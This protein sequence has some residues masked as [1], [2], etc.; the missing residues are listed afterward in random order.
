MLDALPFPRRRFLGLCLG[1]LLAAGILTALTQP[2]SLMRSLP[3]GTMLLD[4]NGQLLRFTT[5]S[6][7]RY[8]L[9]MNLDEYAPVLTDA[10]LTKEDRSFW[11][12]PGVDLPALANAALHSLIL[13]DYHAGAST[14]TMQLVRLLWKLDTD[15]I[16][17]KLL[18]IIDAVGLSV[19]YSK[20]EV[21]E[22]YFNL[23]PCGGNVEG[24]GTASR[25]FFGKAPNR[26]NL[27]EAM[28]LAVLPQDPAHRNP[29]DPRSLPAILNARSQL[30]PQMVQRF[31]GLA[32]RELEL[33]LPL[34]FRHE[35]PFRA[36][37]FSQS[38]IAQW[39]VARRIGTSL[40]LELQTILER[41]IGQ[42]VNRLSGVGITNASAMLVKA[43]TMEVLA[44]VG[45]ADFF[46]DTIQG[47]VNGTTA[48]RSPG[49]TLK[50]FIYAL[51]MD[52][53]VIQ[54]RSI[55]KD[56][57]VH[58]GGY[59]P[60]NFD[61]DFLGPIS[62][63]DALI[64][65]RNVP[66]VSLA[67]KIHDPDLYD[68][69]KQA[70]V[71][72]PYPRSHYGL[73]IVLGGA[74]VTM[75]DLVRLYGSFARGGTIGAIRPVLDIDRHPISADR[76]SIRLF[77]PEAAWL[78]RQ[79]LSAKPRPYDFGD[80]ASGSQMIHEPGA[81]AY[82]TGTSVGFRD[83]WAV[84]VF[85]G[86]ILA[87][88]VGNFDGASNPEF[89]GLRSAAPLFFEIV[90][91]LR[92]G[93]EADVVRNRT[94][95]VQ[96]ARIV[97]AAICRV[98]GQ[99]ATPLC[100]DVVMSPFI[101]GVSPIE[102]CTVHRQ[103]DIDNL[104]GLR[105]SQEIADRTHKETYEIWP[106][107][108]MDIFAQAGLMRRLPPSLD[109]ADNPAEAATGDKPSILSPVAGMQYFYDISAADE[110]IPFISAVASDSK[111]VWWFLDGGLL[112]NAAAR[113]PLFWKPQAGKHEL[114]AVD[115][116]GRFALTNFEVV[117]KTLQQ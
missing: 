104:S 56:T 90:D 59:N 32:K 2:G 114:K 33:E 24:F 103:F 80:Y 100:G 112:G 71:S 75:Q 22:L 54:P 61:N 117:A 101:A 48:Q 20:E 44:S 16:G 28:T 45:S 102:T 97:R 92:A 108:I 3:T 60:D 82:K 18:Q 9:W 12:H 13:K 51:A 67:G 81:V 68:L 4:R 34:Q 72:V 31:P 7:G 76:Q 74:E 113:V 35:L 63:A 109:P 62:A 41:R 10:V 25:I 86:L 55:L 107:D 38:L 99:L 57:R 15:N 70:G 115:D 43:D 17:G 95:P 53:G 46:N 83:A 87:V 40:D 88:W 91:A 64:L 65:S 21:L 52:Q 105:R 79:I 11:V 37:H 30:F 50:P 94:P 116:R 42:F 5:A 26:L 78:V 89:L 29:A 14:I 106:A 84:G 47:Q 19:F 23:A 96:P 1:L 73:S 93:H 39:P 36:P 6:D 98:S 66:A 85:D 111:K 8:R 77:S 110:R 27:A 69:M 58:F 49:S